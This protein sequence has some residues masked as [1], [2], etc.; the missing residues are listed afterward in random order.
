MNNVAAVVRCYVEYTNVVPRVENKEIDK[1]PAN[2]I[3]KKKRMFTDE[4]IKWEK[5][6]GSEIIMQNTV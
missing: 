4:G 6:K 1:M 2:G 3:D 5:W